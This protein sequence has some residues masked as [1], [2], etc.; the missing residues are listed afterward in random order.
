MTATRR[1][2]QTAP[3][4]V[5]IVSLQLAARPALVAT[6][7]PKL[8]GIDKRPVRNLDV[9]QFGV[10]GDQVVDT[11][12]HGGSEQ[13]VYVYSVDDYTWWSSELGLADGELLAPGMFGENVTIDSFGVASIDVGIGDRFLFD[14]QAGSVVLEATAARIPCNTFAAH[15]AQPNWIRRFRD[16]RRPGVYCRVI[17]PGLL[18]TGDTGRREPF[19]GAPITIGDTQ[20][21]FYEGTA[22]RSEDWIRAALASPVQD[23]TRRQLN[24]ELTKRA[25]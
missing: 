14:G 15:M 12:H 10:L 2:P 6:S 25:R 17:T 24:A 13:A 16:A 7:T 23:E 22:E 19:A 4:L 3:D 11:E 1:R 21:L 5:H 9:D 20:D 8:S 18:T